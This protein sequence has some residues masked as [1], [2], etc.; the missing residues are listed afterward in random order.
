MY[1]QPAAVHHSNKPVLVLGV[2]RPGGRVWFVGDCGGQVVGVGVVMVRLGLW[3]CGS[4][5][6]GVGVLMV[7]LGL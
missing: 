7:R 5:V 1:L 3:G 2:P 6:V 4:E